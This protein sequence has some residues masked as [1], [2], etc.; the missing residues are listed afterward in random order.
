MHA[1]AKLEE[2]RYFLDEMQRVRDNLT[3]FRYELSA[4]LGA[5]RSVDYYLR[6]AAK[7]DPA[8]G[9]WYQGV[10]ASI[11][12]GS[13]FP[14]AKYF[15]DQRNFDV[16]AVPV[17][18]HPWSYVQYEVTF[19]DEGLIPT[20]EIQIKTADE[21]QDHEDTLQDVTPAPASSGAAS[22]TIQGPIAIATYEF[23]DRPHEDVFLISSR[24]LVELE[25]ILIEAEQ[26][27]PN[28]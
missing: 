25:R 2:A 8:A 28:L 13:R 22:F 1:R 21:Q 7:A 5:A 18:P 26:Q 9:A 3:A 16:H 14:E 4:F 11:L 6:T 27:F 19:D 12:Q 20:S 23:I 24:Y 17:A 15:I 10:K